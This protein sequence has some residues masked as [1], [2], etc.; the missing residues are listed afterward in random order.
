MTSTRHGCDG[1]FYGAQNR[2]NTQILPL[3]RLRE[4]LGPR[5]RRRALSAAATT[6]VV[7]SPSCI[8]A[9]FY[10]ER[11][12]QHRQLRDKLAR[13]SLHVSNLRGLTFVIFAGAAGFSLFGTAGR[14][15]I[16]LSL[17]ALVAFVSLVVQHARVIGAQ[18]LEE[19]WICVNENASARVNRS[20]WHDLP[21]TGDRFRDAS[22]PYA[23]D[24]DLFGRGSL[25]QRLCVAHTYMGQSRLVE[26]LCGSNDL[27]PLQQRQNLV[28]SLAPQL[29]LR[30]R[31]EVLALAT[32]ETVKKGQ[33]LGVPSDLEPLLNWAEAKP[34]QQRHPWILAAAWALPAITTVSALLCYLG[35]VS[36]PLAIA[37]LALHLFALIKTR[38]QTQV[39]IRMLLRT[40]RMVV[41]VGPLF[42]LLEGC[43]D[44]ELLQRRLRSGPES[45]SVALKSLRR[46]ASWFEL[47]H[48]GLVYPFIN[49]F[50]LW[51]VHCILA[52]E[53]WQQRHGRHLRT[54]FDAIGEMEALSSLAGLYHD[55]PGCCFA[56]VVGE[57]C[58]FEAV[59]LG[60]PL[61]SPE[62]RINNDVT[63][64]R[65]GYGLLVT[66]SNM[67]GKSTYLRAIGLAAVLGLAGGPVCAKRLRIAQLQVATS[68]RI[69]DSLA[70]GVSHFYAELQ[71]LKRVLD[72]AHGEHSVLFLLDEILHGT[73]S[74]E[75]RIGARFILAELLRAGAF[76]AV[77]THDLALCEM[78]G[79]LTERLALV[80]FRESVVNDEMTFDYRLYP[81]SVTEGNA[82]RL[83]QRLGIQ[84]PL[85]AEC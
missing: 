74:R 79:D 65:H 56:E 1:A 43:S 28:Q 71:K 49:L 18:D 76:G 30:Q 40:E 17:A 82:L 60:H 11:A 25:F 38:P 22:H 31:F 5:Y 84:V 6:L 7:T 73:N 42:E 68:M 19:R 52:F 24:L 21:N 64:L 37:P 78:S 29:E 13:R 26:L 51:D 27:G 85:D 53:Q 62:V 3:T 67:S 69:S 54:W 58:G 50:L 35:L 70:G 34:S 14:A 63:C 10:E 57:G 46:I 33:E 8:S 2:E 83:M 77:S 32:R 36:I 4:S 61:L 41:N 72:A 59:S 39:V 75:R 12:R 80:H 47:R 66:G 55:E 16:A 44:L 81:G 9:D 23:D 45:P 15:G 20:L 48:N